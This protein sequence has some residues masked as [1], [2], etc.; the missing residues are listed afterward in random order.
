MNA[1]EKVAEVMTSTEGAQRNT[2]SLL[3]QGV[4]ILYVFAGLLFTDGQYILALCAVFFALRLGHIRE[5]F[6]DYIQYKR[7]GNTKTSK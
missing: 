1:V 5:V 7:D 6:K 3:N 4:M 2:R